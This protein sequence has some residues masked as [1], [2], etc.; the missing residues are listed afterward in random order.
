MADPMGPKSTLDHVVEKL[1]EMNKDQTTLQKEAVIYSHELQDYVQNEGHAM[2]NAQLRSMQDLILALQEGRLDDIEASKEELVRRRA[3]E[4][5]DE[6]RNDRLKDVFKQLKKQYKLLKKEFGDDG[7]SVIG[8]I[9]RTA[10]VGLLIGAVQGIGSIYVNIFKKIGLKI[11]GAAIG[12]TKMFQLDVLFKNLK[13]GLGDFK[14]RFVNFF[15]NSRFAKFFTSGN[16]GSFFS[17]AF[18][19]FMNIAKDIGMLIKNQI[20]N[21]RKIGQALLGLFTGAPMAFKGLTE[22]KF[23]IKA[24]SWIFKKAGEFI[25]WVKG[26]IVAKFVDLAD[27]VKNAF[28][29]VF[30]KVGQFVDRLTGIF[31]GK[32]ESRFSKFGDSLRK[33]FSKSGPLSRF[34]GFFSAIQN[35][36]IQVGKILGKIIWP[37]V[38][39]IGGIMGAFKDAKKET[40]KTNSIIR[41]AI[42]F[43]RGA[44]R[45][46]IGEFIDFV[47]LAVGWLLDLLPGIDGAKETFTAFSFAD[48]FDELY[49]A[50]GDF[51]IG[52]L[53]M[54]RDIVADI[55]IGGL[56]K[57][58]LMTI[59]MIFTKILDYPIAI[60]K[61]AAAAFGALPPGPPS[62][63]DAF[64]EAYNAHMSAGL[65][66]ALKDKMPKMDGLDSEGNEIAFL[67]DQA[68]YKFGQGEFSQLNQNNVSNTGGDS[69][70]ITGTIDDEN[71][72]NRMF[73]FVNR[74][75]PLP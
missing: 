53:N 62:P 11:K 42:G 25:N 6:E 8:L 24:D 70:T 27:G 59:G 51:I 75:T 57:S 23:G 63:Q 34:F 46:L 45:I 32:T 38:G 1:A 15:K 22:L 20:G 61:G 30:N 37:I 52:T 74:H 71:S 49:Y 29:V 16:K 65:T 12:V 64:M 2:S 21:A 66:K 19:G 48:F 31:T 26:P 44:F 54:I 36:F 60:A 5:R 72:F 73:N 41:G 40:D 9:F 14:N 35:A 7:I 18:G 47:L 10:L 50:I 28:T 4:K 13:N 39:A 17:T 33:F 69:V 58:M 43:I 3:E 67:S 68:K 56:I 55:G